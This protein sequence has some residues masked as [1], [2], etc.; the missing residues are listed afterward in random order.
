MTVHTRYLTAKEAAALIGV[1]ESALEKG[2]AGYGSFQP[3]YVRIGRSVRYPLDQL[4]GW[5]E[6][7]RRR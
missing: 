1:S 7:F 2:R 4:M 3:P 5:L 6:Q